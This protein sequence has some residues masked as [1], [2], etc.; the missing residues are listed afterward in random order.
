MMWLYRCDDDH[1][2][3]VAMKMVLMMLTMGMTKVIMIR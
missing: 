1:G 2:D 3:V